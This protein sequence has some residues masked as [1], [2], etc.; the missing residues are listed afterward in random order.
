MLVAVEKVTVVAELC[1]LDAYRL[2]AGGVTLYKM[3]GRVPGG[4]L[5]TA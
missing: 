5:L 3:S 4:K 2:L 1:W